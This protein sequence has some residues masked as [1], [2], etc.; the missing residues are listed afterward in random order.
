MKFVRLTFQYLS[1]EY[2]KRL[3]FL[4]LIILPASLFFAIAM[5]IDNFVE[6]FIQIFSGSG[7]KFG[8]L[9]LNMLPVSSWRGLVSLLFAI[10]MMSVSLAVASK[11][12]DR[13]MRVGVFK[14][15]GFFRSINENFIRTFISIFF[16][17]ASIFVYC[18]FNGCFAA[19]WLVVFKGTVPALVFS[20]IIAL[21]LGFLLMMFLTASIF[22]L[23]IMITSGV[24]SVTAIQRS[25]KTTAPKIGKIMYGI[26]FVFLVLLV[27]SFLN[28]LVVSSRFWRVILDFLCYEMITLFYSVY[29]YVTYY[30][31][32]GF[33]RADLKTWERIR[34]KD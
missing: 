11:F 20:I 19:L 15:K 7:E 13:S 3:L 31:V 34:Y 18:F 23:P 8:L 9:I 4:A 27:F 1:A 33:E 21:G 2:G 22:S 16:L 29:I 6:A 5:P 14:V 24:N 25:L 17:I 12:I 32:F 26:L 30:D 28:A 10:I